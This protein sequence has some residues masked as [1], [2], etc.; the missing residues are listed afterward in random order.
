MCFIGNDLVKLHRCGFAVGTHHFK[1]QLLNDA[2]PLRRVRGGFQIERQNFQPHGGDGFQ[3]RWKYQNILRTGSD[4][5]IGFE[6]IVTFPLR[7]RQDRLFCLGLHGMNRL[8]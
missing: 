7:D 5:G 8:P 6:F 4:V 2:T 3:I 1:N